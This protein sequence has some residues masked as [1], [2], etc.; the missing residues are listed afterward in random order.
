MADTILIV[1]LLS[2]E[3][4]IGTV[5]TGDSSVKIEK[6]MIV[7]LSPSKTPGD[8]NVHLFPYLAFAKKNEIEI[9][10]QVIVSVYE[11]VEALENKYREVFGSGIIKPS[12]EIIQK[13]S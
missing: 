3:E 12:R 1:R 4:L 9:S 2:G 13:I 6:P 11:P 8:V 5:T 7:Q 10:K